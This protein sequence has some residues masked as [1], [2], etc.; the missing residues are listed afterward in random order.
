MCHFSE[1]FRHFIKNIRHFSE[2]FRHFRKNIRH[3]SEII[4]HVSK[5]ICRFSEKNALIYGNFGRRPGAGRAGNQ[6]GSGPGG[7]G[8]R[9]VPTPDRTA[10]MCGRGGRECKKTEQKKRPFNRNFRTL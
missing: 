2:I 1:I 4:C 3:F 6:N 9:N 10:V 8:R 7:A 5:N